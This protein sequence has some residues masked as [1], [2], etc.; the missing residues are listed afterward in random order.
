MG[1]T[2]INQT[3]NKQ[4][5]ILNDSPEGIEGGY[6]DADMVWHEIGQNI[7]EFVADLDVTKLEKGKGLSN[8]SPY[9]TASAKR[10]S[11]ADFDL[12][13]P[14]G[15]FYYFEGKCNYPCYFGCQWYNTNVITKVEASQNFT[16][17]DIFDSGTWMPLTGYIEEVPAQ[18]NS[19][20][21]KGVRITFRPD[22]DAN[23]PDDFEIE[24]LKIYAA[25]F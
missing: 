4:T 16:T 19:S 22:P 25:E 17:S 7:F 8:N 23:L 9:T 15:K 20:D 13:L 11:Y 3:E 1:R 24:Y 5:V 2:V 21:I 18:K 10:E 6:F 12:R 14:G